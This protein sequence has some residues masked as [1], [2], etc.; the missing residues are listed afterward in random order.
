MV[1]PPNS[2]NARVPFGTP[3]HTRSS[4]TGYLGIKHLTRNQI[5]DVMS[6]EM[7]PF[8]LGPMPPEEFLSTF[9]PSLQPSSFQAHMFDTLASPSSEASKYAIFVSDCRIPQKFFG[10][11]EM[12]PD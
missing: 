1:T 5:Y 6:E 11:E 9:L 10:T 2:S 12:S 8:F 3:V 7:A 4:T